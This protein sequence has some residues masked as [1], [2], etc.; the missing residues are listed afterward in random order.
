MIGLRVSGRASVIEVD[1][2]SSLDCWGPGPKF[3]SNSNKILV[4]IFKNVLF[5][6]VLAAVGAAAYGVG[7][8]FGKLEKL[9]REKT[10]A[11]LLDSRGHTARHWSPT[12]LC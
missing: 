2:F 8:Y 12:E 3:M 4:P 9:R 11:L 7:L 5:W 6:I 1:R 10:S